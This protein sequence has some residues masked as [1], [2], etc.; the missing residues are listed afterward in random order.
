MRVYA[1]P[2]SRREE[3]NARPSTFESPSVPGNPCHNIIP[4]VLWNSRHQ[5]HYHAVTASNRKGQKPAQAI[6]TASDSTIRIML[7]NSV[8]PSNHRHPPGRSARR[9][10]RSF[11]P[12]PSP[13]LARRKTPHFAGPRPQS[14]RPY[15]GRR[16]RA[17]SSLAPPFSSCRRVQHSCGSARCQRSCVGRSPPHHLRPRSSKVRLRRAPTW[18]LFLQAFPPFHLC[19]VLASASATAP[20]RLRSVLVPGR[21]SLPGVQEAAVPAVGAEDAAQLPHNAAVKTV[22]LACTPPTLPVIHCAGQRSASASVRRTLIPAAVPV[23]GH[24]HHPHH[25]HPALTPLGRS[26]PGPGGRLPSHNV[27]LFRC[28]REPCVSLPRRSRA[29]RPSRCQTAS[30]ATLH[31]LRSFRALGH[32]ETLS[33]ASAW[34]ASRKGTTSPASTTRLRDSQQPRPTKRLTPHPQCVIHRHHPPDGEERE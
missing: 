4:S 20:A 27:G 8:G 18:P 3:N 24:R 21:K 10:E 11:A 16:E 26:G 19:A 25:R 28:S 30:R 33:R 32:W 22:S 13:A 1:L 23:R 14:A 34:T 9:Q 5:P 6:F 15:Q 17:P 2:A 31:S 7:R 12:G 29:R